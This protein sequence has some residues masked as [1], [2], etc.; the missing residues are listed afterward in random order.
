LTDLIHTNA[1]AVNSAYETI[2]NIAITPDGRFVT[3]IANTND[4]STTCVQLWDAT[5]GNST[6]VSGN[7]DGQVPE[8]S[9]CDFPT[10]DR[11]GRLIL[12]QSSAAGLTTNDLNGD[13]HFYVRDMMASSTVLVDA[14]TNG[15]GS[16]ISPATVPS[17]SADARF[18]AFDCVDASLVPNDRNRASDAFVRDLV[19]ASNELISVHDPA[20]PCMTPNGPSLL[21]TTSV[22]ADGGRIAFASEAD[23]LVPNDTN[24]VRDIFVRDVETGKTVLASADTNG[25]SADGCR[26]TRRSAPMVS[27]SRLRATLITLY[28]GIPT[29]LKMCSCGICSLG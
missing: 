19:A 11:T 20:L 26:L 8:G 28:L 13:Y 2:Q 27:L 4:I 14:D 17:M 18:V 23:N 29:M 24:G 3:F 15:V 21:A 12:F 22:S 5:T 7:M 16:P 6:L 10:I 25:F 9:T 1:A